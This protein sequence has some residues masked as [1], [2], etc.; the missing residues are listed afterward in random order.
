[1]KVPESKT[2]PGTCGTPTGVAIARGQS[3]LR[4]GTAGSLWR[5]RQGAFRLERPVGE[6][7]SVVHL[8][9]PGDLVGLEGL[10]AEPFA[11]TVSALVASTATPEP[12]L[13]EAALAAT[14]AEALLQQQRQSFDMALL[15]SGTAPVRLGHLLR[16]L[17]QAFGVQREALDRKALPALKDMAQIID[18]TPETVCRE[19]NRLLPMR[20]TKRAPQRH[21]DWPEARVSLASAC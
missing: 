14:L 1:M 5:V 7:L 20:N 8:A 10:C 6:S 3:L 9:L 2:P 13:G 11:C 16:L 19:L 12:V 4:A 18:S 21:R 17:A 15:R